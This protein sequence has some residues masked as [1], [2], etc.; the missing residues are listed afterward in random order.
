MA[1]DSSPVTTPPKLLGPDYFRLKTP[2]SFQVPSSMKMHETSSTTETSHTTAVQLEIDK[3]SFQDNQ[4]KGTCPTGQE[5]KDHQLQSPGKE[6]GLTT[7]G[8]TLAGNEKSIAEEKV[9]SSESSKST[10]KPTHKAQPTIKTRTTPIAEAAIL[11]EQLSQQQ[12]Q[13]QQQ[14]AQTSSQRTPNKRSRHRDWPGREYWRE[15]VKNLDL[16]IASIS[17]QQEQGTSSYKQAG[18]KS[19]RHVDW[20]GREYWRK[21]VGS[22]V[23]IGSSTS[24]GRYH[25]SESKDKEC[26][27]QVPQS[28]AL[29]SGSGSSVAG[30]EK[31]SRAPY[32]EPYPSTSRGVSGW[33]INDLD[34]S[35]TGPLPTT[36]PF[37]HTTD[38]PPAST[39]VQQI[40][41]TE[42][43]I[44]PSSPKSI[45]EA[46]PTKNSSHTP[47]SVSSVSRAE[48]FSSSEAHQL[49]EAV[50]MATGS[51]SS[52]VALANI[53]Q[54]D[55]YSRA[56]DDSYY[57]NPIRPVVD[58]RRHGGVVGRS[59]ETASD[60]ELAR[61]MQEELDAESAKRIQQDNGG[62]SSQYRERGK[63]QLGVH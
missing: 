57:P 16:R 18:N 36:T 7:P 30:I 19:S 49:S 52:D 11:R 32:R 15:E 6:E 63:Y 41:V 55:E 35:D 48:G 14:Q 34:A 8:A 4:L 26:R 42:N 22:L 59:V 9:R 61:L 2:A 45:Q 43:F 38:S 21:E 20:P 24:K 39:I 51:T 27:R 37:L 60:Y 1:Y 23:S 58:K 33:F 17:T 13:Q 50:F 44:L 54:S 40:S 12:Q 10:A 25:Q 62:G 47:T 53:L 31:P 3:E 5:S 29:S 28:L 56:A 46:Q